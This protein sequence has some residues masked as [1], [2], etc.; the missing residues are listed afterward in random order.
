[1]YQTGLIT[2]LDAQQLAITSELIADFIEVKEK[3]KDEGYLLSWTNRNGGTSTRISPLYK[4]KLD[5]IQ[6]IR[7]ALN[8]FGLSPVVR[9]R[10]APNAVEPPDDPLN[11]LLS[12][13]GSKVSDE[14]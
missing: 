8:D 1:M 12:K 2:A 13:L 5:L 6:K 4:L 7:I 10:L 11:E 9:T 3:L 14:N